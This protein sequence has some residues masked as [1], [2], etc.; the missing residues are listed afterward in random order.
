MSYAHFISETKVIKIYFKGN[1]NAY[2]Y[3]ISEHE[4]KYSPPVTGTTN[5][6]KN[7]SEFIALNQALLE[8]VEKYAN[9]KVI[10]KTYSNYKTIPDLIKNGKSG[11]L[12]NDYY[13]TFLKLSHGLKIIT[14]W[15]R[16]PSGTAKSTSEVQGKEKEEAREK[17][18]ELKLALD[19]H[20]SNKIARKRSK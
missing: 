16:D 7:R 19:E 11:G 6:P 5:T 15:I 8:C 17:L 14:T 20:R 18:N 4:S 2:S 12:L 10:I 9:K 13:K 1:D 3:I